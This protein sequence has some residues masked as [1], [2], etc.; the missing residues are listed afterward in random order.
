MGKSPADIEKW[1]ALYEKM[2]LRRA[3]RVD[4]G[5][6]MDLIRK[7]GEHGFDANFPIPIDRSSQILDGAHRAACSAAF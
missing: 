4:T 5:A 3:G 7:F 2:Q 1:K 6:F